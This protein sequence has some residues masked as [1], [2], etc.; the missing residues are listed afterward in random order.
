MKTQTFNIVA[1]I[2]NS[3]AIEIAKAA[4]TTKPTY[5]AAKIQEFTEGEADSA[6]V[7]KLVRQKRNVFLQVVHTARNSATEV[8]TETETKKCGRK[9]LEVG[10]GNAEV[11]ICVAIENKTKYIVLSRIAVLSCFDYEAENLTFK[12]DLLQ[13]AISAYS[14]QENHIER[15]RAAYNPFN[16]VEKVDDIVVAV[17]QHAEIVQH[18]IDTKEVRMQKREERQKMLA[19]RAKRRENR[20]IRKQIK[21]LKARLVEKYAVE[22]EQMCQAKKDAHRAKRKAAKQAA[23]SVAVAA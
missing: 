4:Q 19:E 2:N 5:K 3:E 8:V 13:E 1:S 17:R 10:F 12:S 11:F 14:N 16:N 15:K 18:R 23:V 6:L 20:A 9:P 21:D 7:E 22:F